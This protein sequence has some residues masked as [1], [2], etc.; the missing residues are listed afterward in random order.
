MFLMIVFVVPGVRLKCPLRMN[1]VVSVRRTSKSD[2][3]EA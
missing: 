3:S 2:L 1:S